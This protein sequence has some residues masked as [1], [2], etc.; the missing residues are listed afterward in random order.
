[1]IARGIVAF[2]VLGMVFVPSAAQSENT[3]WDLIIQANLESGLILPGQV[4][5]V[6]G[7][8]SDHAGK[9]VQGA[10]IAIKSGGLSWDGTTD[11]GGDFRQELTG[12]EGSP[13]S[14]VVNIRAESEEEMGLSALQFRVHGD[15]RESEVLLRQIDAAAA[16][17]Y[18]ES[19]EED[20]LNDLIGM[21]LY[22]H[23]QEIYGN[24]LKALALEREKAEEMAALD[25]QREEA[26][27]LLQEAIEEGSPGAGVYA[28]W[29]HDR[30]VDNLDLS[31]RDTIGSQLNHT[32]ASFYEAREM[33]NSVLED[34][35]TYEEAREAYMDRLSMTREMMMGLTSEVEVDGITNSTAAGDAEMVGEETAVEPAEAGDSGTDGADIEVEASGNSIF[36]SIGGTVI[37]F[38]VNG[39]QL[40]QVTNSTQ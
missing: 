33:M 18:I 7:Q 29:A 37:E 8:V 11:E 28:G 4:P 40:I 30:F 1:V 39:T 20:F 2:A 32:A 16:Q 10:S 24:Y 17:K 25:G 27:R 23:Y 38:V 13:G 34:G 14:Y 36:I 31:V 19:G 12:F 3:L 6:A 26:A 5:I 35:G 21:Q 9:P 15:V 22:H